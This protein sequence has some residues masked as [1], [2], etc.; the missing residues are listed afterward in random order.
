MIPGYCALRAS[1]FK[2]I[3]AFRT[4]AADVPPHVSISGTLAT[5][6]QIIL[7]RLPAINTDA[8]ASA[9]QSTSHLTRRGFLLG[10]WEP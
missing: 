6:L 9:S 4:G 8:A 2:H 10:K 7:A 3:A 5:A 1:P